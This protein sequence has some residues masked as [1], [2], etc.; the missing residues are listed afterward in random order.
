MRIDLSNILLTGGSGTLGTQ[1]IKSKLFDNLLTPSK[2]VLDITKLT[3][4]NNFFCSNEI[5]FV[6]HCAGLSKMAICEDKPQDAIRTNIIGWPFLIS[7]I[8]SFNN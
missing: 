1:I 4:I 5:D 6:I 3:S 7:G 2:Q 8:I